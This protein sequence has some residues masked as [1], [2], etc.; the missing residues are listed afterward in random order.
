MRS[1]IQVDRRR[2][3]DDGAPSKFWTLPAEGHLPL[4]A[5][6]PRCCVARRGR[7]AL[8]VTGHHHQ[9]GSRFVTWSP[10]AAR[11]TMPPHPTGSR[12]QR[13]VPVDS[14]AGW[15][16][17]RGRT[18]TAT[19]SSRPVAT[20]N[21]ADVLLAANQAANTRRPAPWPIPPVFG[22]AA[23]LTPMAGSH[24]TAGHSRNRAELRLQGLV[25]TTAAG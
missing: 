13:D 8:A 24:R 21:P 15:C 10:R 3:H 11:R 5:A 1:D 16:E 14:P 6:P 4:A 9:P 2:S 17:H 19:R 20:G 23:A 7:L 12:P 18:G 22:R 25:V